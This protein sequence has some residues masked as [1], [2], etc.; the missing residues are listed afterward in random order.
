MIYTR[1]LLYLFTVEIVY[2][3]AESYKCLLLMDGTMQPV[4]PSHKGKVLLRKLIRAVHSIIFSLD[5]LQ[6]FPIRFDYFLVPITGFL[7]DLV[8]IDC[9]DHFG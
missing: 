7:D 4:K 8:I 1:N 2:T 6:L 9:S 3:F 5:V